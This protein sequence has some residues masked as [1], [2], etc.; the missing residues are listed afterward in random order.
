MKAAAFKKFL[1]Y[2]RP[3]FES[4]NYNIAIMQYYDLKLN[5]LERF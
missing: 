5:E 4:N 1:N 2:A 3:Q